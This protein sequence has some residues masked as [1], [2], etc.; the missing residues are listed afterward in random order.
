LDQLVQL[1]KDHFEL[2]YCSTPLGKQVVTILGDQSSGKSSLIN[3]LFG[4]NVRVTG[5]HA[6]DSQFTIIESVP[7]SEFIEMLQS[8]SS[9]STASAEEEEIRL[10]MDRKAKELEDRMGPNWLHRPVQRLETDPRK[11]LVWLELKQLSKV[12]RYR[13][14]FESHMKSIFLKYDSLVKCIIVNERFVSGSELSKLKRNSNNNDEKMMKKEK[15]ILEDWDMLGYQSNGRPTVCNLIMIDSP[16]FNDESVLDVE[17]FRANI[18]LLEFFYR[19]SSLVLFMASP[20]HILSMGNALHM[21][22]LTVLDQ[23]TRNRMFNQVHQQMASTINSS[24]NTNKSSMLTSIISSCYSALETRVSSIIS[25]A[26][27]LT[28][29]Y[30]GGGSGLA[31][32]AQ[33]TSS[34]KYFGASI[35]DKLYFVINKADICRNPHYVYYEF[36]TALGRR[37]KHLPIPPA[38]HIL[39][40]GVPMEQRTHRIALWNVEQKITEDVTKT[41]PIETIPVGQL[42][43][44]EYILDMLKEDKHVQTNL[45][46]HIQYVFEKVQEVYNGMSYYRQFVTQKHFQQ[47]KSICDNCCLSGD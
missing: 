4:C 26:G 2:D 39:L 3:H 32:S 41:M 17:K 19:Q 43:E 11:G 25:S 9:A 16:G 40:I 45:I 12:R 7:E 21:L 18:D 46:N 24:S 28:E 47:A 35:Y 14:F 22:Q 13:Q 6:V 44:L 42:M 15:Q 10:S 27:N 5:E 34:Y 31:S 30:F 29:D 36:G 23:N 33:D 38:S 37:F 1:A 20:T 8:F